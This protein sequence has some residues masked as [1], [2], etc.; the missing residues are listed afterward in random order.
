MRFLN[1]I[2]RAG[3]AGAMVL[4]LSVLFVGAAGAHSHL[5]SSDPANG[6]VLDAAPTTISAVFDEETSLTKS[7]FQVFYAADASSA[8]VA[9]DNGDGHVD[10][11]ERTK[12]SATLKPDLGPGIYTVKW[13]TVTED[14]NGQLDGTFSFS[15]RGGTA[16]AGGAT[17][18]TSS[19][20]TSSGG[21]TLPATGQPYPLLPLASLLAALVLLAGFDLRRRALR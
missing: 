14:D 10:V 20:G 1:S 5:K 6:A 16:D 4:L 12:M 17:G 9:A 7:T 21:T 19:G 8:Q 15:V 2:L 11:N 3:M 13:H 18:G